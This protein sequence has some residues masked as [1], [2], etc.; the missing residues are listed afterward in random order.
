MTTENDVTIHEKRID[1]LYKKHD[2]LRD[3]VRSLA[4]TMGE[5]Q[6]AQSKSDA[7]LDSLLDSLA[8]MKSS[9]TTEVGVRG[10]HLFSLLTIVVVIAGLSGSLIKNS[11]DSMEKLRDAQDRELDAKLGGVSKLSEERSR[12]IEKLQDIQRD[13]FHEHTDGHPY[14][15][16]AK[17]EGLEALVHNLIGDIKESR[18]NDLH[19][20]SNRWTREDEMQSEKMKTAK[21]LNGGS[22]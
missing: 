21:E 13:N 7:K 2:S 9:L 14:S 16:I 17:F 22:Q 20:A 11:L 6:V 8:D 10:K 19:T 18:K 12:W 4:H 1:D 5:M 3:D 15:V